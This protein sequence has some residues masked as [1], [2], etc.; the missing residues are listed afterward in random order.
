VFDWRNDKWR[1]NYNRR[2]GYDEGAIRLLKNT[3]HK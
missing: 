1:G 2:C 3:I